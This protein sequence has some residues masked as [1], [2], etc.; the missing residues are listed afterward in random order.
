MRRIL[1]V[2]DDA[3]LALLLGEPLTGAGAE[4]C[5]AHSFDEVMSQA[6]EALNCELAILDVNL[7]ASQPTGVDVSTWLRSQSFQGPVIFLTGH[8]RSNPMVREAAS[9]PGSRVLAKPIAAE[10]LALLAEAGP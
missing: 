9:V 7:G 5:V 4:T 8:A 2:E 10:E 1:I 6:A 3:D